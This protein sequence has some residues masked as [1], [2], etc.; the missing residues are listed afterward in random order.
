MLMNQYIKSQKSKTISVILNNKF[1][2]NKL[3][4]LDWNKKMINKTNSMNILVRN[5]K[6]I[7]SFSI[8]DQTVS[9]YFRISVV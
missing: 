4:N 6:N 1:Q 9:K 3:V 2:M 5:S 7:K 8:K